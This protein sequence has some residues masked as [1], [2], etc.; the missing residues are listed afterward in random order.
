ML[1]DFIT[2]KERIIF[3]P[4]ERGRLVENM[5]VIKF[6]ELKGKILSEIYNEDNLRIRFI[7]NEKEVYL[8]FH[9]QDCCEDVSIED[10]EGDL[11]DLLDSTILQAEEACDD[12]LPPKDKYDDR[13]IWTF[14]KLA[15]I[16]GSV[17]IRWYGTSNGYYSEKVSFF[18]E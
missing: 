5:K 15:T 9:K 18:K 12:A 11:S 1:K 16:K 17:T 8:L 14:Y 6:E 3:K 2:A 10:I 4:Y 13:W 7:T